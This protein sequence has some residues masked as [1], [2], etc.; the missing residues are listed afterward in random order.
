MLLITLL[1]HVVFHNQSR[2]LSLDLGGA[3][4]VNALSTVISAVLLLPWAS[5]I[6]NSTQVMH[7]HIYF[8]Y[9]NL[10]LGMKV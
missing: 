2:K 3:K 5:F 9:T 1:A 7:R 6:S 10:V 8:E 4:R